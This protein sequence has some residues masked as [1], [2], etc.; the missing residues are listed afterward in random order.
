MKRKFIIISLVA[1]VLLSGYY[2]YKSP[3]SKR[4]GTE[5]QSFVPELTLRDIN[6]V[7][8]VHGTT[9]WSLHVK[10]ALKAESTGILKGEGVRL[11]IFKKG[12]PMVYLTADRG[13]AD[14]RKGRFRVWGNVVITAQE[15]NCTLM[16]QEMEYDEKAKSIYSNREVEFSC[17][18][19]T[20]HGKGMVMDL[21]KKSIKIDGLVSALMK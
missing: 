10:S 17:N 20:L 4:S 3:F 5:V 8:N 18:D 16:A 13:E 15:G 2:L 9:A 19:L 14:I 12:R 6:Y 21:N 7:K 11:N 1:V